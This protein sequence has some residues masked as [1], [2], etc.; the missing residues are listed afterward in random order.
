M[1][2]VN[3]ESKLFERNMAVNVALE[4]IDRLLAGLKAFQPHGS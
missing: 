2:R 1:Q 4:N 3:L